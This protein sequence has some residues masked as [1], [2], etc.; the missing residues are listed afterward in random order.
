LTHPASAQARLSIGAGLLL[1]VESLKVSR[2]ANRDGRKDGRY[3][4]VDGRLSMV[5]ENGFDFNFVGLRGY[6]FEEVGIPYFARVA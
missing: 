2:R 4:D 5:A 1:K 3:S 6:D